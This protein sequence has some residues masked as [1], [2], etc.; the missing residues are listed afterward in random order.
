MRN[1]HGRTAKTAFNRLSC[2]AFRLARVSSQAVAWQASSHG[3][4]PISQT[5]VAVL[6]SLQ[7]P[8]TSCC[9]RRDDPWRISAQLLGHRTVIWWQL[10]ALRN[11]PKPLPYRYDSVRLC[12]ISL[13]GWD[14]PTD[15]VTGHR[16]LQRLQY[17]II[18]DDGS[19]PGTR[20]R[21]DIKPFCLTLSDSSPYI[22]ARRLDLSKL[23]W[24]LTQC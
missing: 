11:L 17:A 2:T 19:H 21:V 13:Q 22:L 14:P 20:S 24:Q 12:S 6:L 5:G 3:V 7:T 23:R 15:E 10:S 4:F 16:T 1:A 8:V 9:H 18:S